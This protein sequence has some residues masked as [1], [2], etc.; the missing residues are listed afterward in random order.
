MMKKWKEP[1][2]F[3]MLFGCL[4]FAATLAAQPGKDKKNNGNNGS[5]NVGKWEL[6]GEKEVD[7]VKE[8]DVFNAKGNGIYAAFKLKVLNSRVK[9]EKMV[10]EYDNGRKQSVDLN[11]E[12]HV[13]IFSAQPIGCWFLSVT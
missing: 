8:W 5:K 3:L 10:I 4:L 1:R 7:R 13:F 11:K 9:F 2:W 6:P 12:I